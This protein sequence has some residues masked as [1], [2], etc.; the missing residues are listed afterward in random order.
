MTKEFLAVAIISF[1]SGYWDANFEKAKSK[2]D[3]YHIVRRFGI[4]WPACIG[5]MIPHYNLE[6]VFFDSFVWWKYGI[7]V[8]L[9]G[10][11]SFVCF[12][13]AV[14]ISG[15]YEAWYGNGSKNGN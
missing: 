1:C 8:V 5:W 11:L 4:L 14:Y 10:I 6:R 12:R 15:K 9:C 2:W 13:F 7:F 3:F